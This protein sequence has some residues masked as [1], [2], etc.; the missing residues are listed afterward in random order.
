MQ[1]HVE[2]N[3]ISIKTTSDI[4]RLK[5]RRHQ[6]KLTMLGFHQIG[7]NQN[8]TWILIKCKLKIWLGENMTEINNW[9]KN[10]ILNPVTYQKYKSK[11]KSA[12]NRIQSKQKRKKKMKRKKSNRIELWAWA[13]FTGE[14]KRF[15]EEKDRFGNGYFILV[16]LIASEQNN[17]FQFGPQRINNLSIEALEIEQMSI[18]KLNMYQFTRTWTE[19]LFIATSR[20]FI[21]HMQSHFEMN[22]Y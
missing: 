12:I 20:K 10:K 18:I 11:N 7:G 21:S 15:G 9:L 4:H 8:R 16:F 13:N 5:L 2:A 1:L 22:I 6:K 14:E 17:H 19:L 3:W